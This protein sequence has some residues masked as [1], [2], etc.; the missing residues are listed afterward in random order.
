MARQAAK[1][2]GTGTLL[3]L[4]YVWRCIE[5]NTKVEVDFCDARETKTKVYGDHHDSERRNS[6]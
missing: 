4:E 6:I 2:Y 3:V 5:I 1:V